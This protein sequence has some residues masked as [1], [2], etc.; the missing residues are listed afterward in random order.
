MSHSRNNGIFTTIFIRIN[1]L[2]KIYD[3]IPIYQQFIDELKEDIPRIEAK[4]PLINE[5]IALLFRYEIDIDPK[6]HFLFESSIQI[7]VFF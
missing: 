4:L 2:P 5:E 3:E 6:V 1:I 7:F